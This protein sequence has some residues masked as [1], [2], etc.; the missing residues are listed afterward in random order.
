MS[1]RRTRRSLRRCQVGEHP[2]R[3]PA[4]RESPAGTDGRSGLAP[5]TVSRCERDHMREFPPGAGEDK[6]FL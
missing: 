3:T 6:F 4:A 2:Q 5:G 1:W